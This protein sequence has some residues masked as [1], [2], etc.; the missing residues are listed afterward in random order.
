MA[1]SSQARFR[2]H[3]DKFRGPRR[4]G[5]TQCWMWKGQESSHHPIFWDGSTNMTAARYVLQ[6][7]LGRKLGR[8]EFACH[9]CDNPHCVRPSHIFLG[10]PDDN[11][12]DMVKKNRK[13]RGSNVFGAKLTE[14][15][16]SDLRKRFTRGR[17]TIKQLAQEYNIHPFVMSCALSGRTW[18]HVGGPLIVRR[19]NKRPPN[20]TEADVR[21]IRECYAQHNITL[22][23]LAKQYDLTESNIH[24]IVRGHTWKHVDGPIDARSRCKK[25]RR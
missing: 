18:K 24:H 14:A 20:I 15:I 10:S 6:R 2:R 5:M 3:V 17:V 7:R 1:L 23:E 25:E 4:R 21:R 13:E 22:R 9:H 8:W 11:S 16:V 19:P 12:K